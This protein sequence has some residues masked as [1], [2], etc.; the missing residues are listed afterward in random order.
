MLPGENTVVPQLASRNR[1]SSGTSIAAPVVLWTCAITRFAA[2]ALNS[3][4]GELVSMLNPGCGAV[5]SYSVPMLPGSIRRP[6]SQ[7]FGG[8][9]GAAPN[10]VNAE[11][12]AGLLSSGWITESWKVPAGLTQIECVNPGCAASWAGNLPML[13]YRSPVVGSWVPSYQNVEPSSM[14]ESSELT[15]F[16]CAVPSVMSVPA[17]VGPPDAADVPAV[18]HSYVR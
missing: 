17:P 15:S 9:G 16:Q 5:G 10:A 2:G 14:P 8:G 12:T 13:V 1:A 7:P 4:G 11:Y 3:L 6:V 18:M